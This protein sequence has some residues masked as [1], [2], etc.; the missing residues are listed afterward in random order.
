MDWLQK[1]KKIFVCYRRADRPA[2]A[3]CIAQHLMREFGSDNVFID[4][5]HV[6]LGENFETKVRKEVA[7]CR[8]MLVIIGPDW[9]AFDV[10]TGRPRV[11]EDDDLVR[12]EIGEA[13]RQKLTVIPIIVHG[14]RLPSKAELPPELA[15]LPLLNAQKITISRFFTDMPALATS[16]R[17]V[18]RLPLVPRSH[19][20]WRARAYA[21]AACA[22]STI[23]GGAVVHSGMVEAL[24][25]SPGTI[26]ALGEVAAAPP[27]AGSIILGSASGPV[28][29]PTPFAAHPASMPRV[30]PPAAPPPPAVPS[31]AAKQIPRDPQVMV[32]RFNDTNIPA[33]DRET[34]AR[35]LGDI[36]YIPLQRRDGHP[37]PWLSA[38]PEQLPPR[39]QFQDCENCPEMVA[40]PTGKF[41]MGSNG[42]ATNERDAFE[43][44]IEMPFAI[45][46]TETT[47]SQYL[48]YLREN[49]ISPSTWKCDRNLV[50]ME[51]GRQRPVEAQQHRNEPANCVSWQDA[52]DYVLW[53]SRRTGRFYRLPSEAEWEYAA[54]AGGAFGLDGA[55]LCAYANAQLPRSRGAHLPAG[56]GTPLCEKGGG[57]LEVASGQSNPFALHDMHGSVAE[58]VLDCYHESYTEK[59]SLLRRR[60]HEAWA[61]EPHCNKAT[62]RGTNSAVVV[63]GV[64]RGGHWRSGQD[65]VRSTAREPQNPNSR[66]TQIGFRVVRTLEKR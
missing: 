34:L 4:I 22:A 19:R 20:K 16:L 8:V 10:N 3:L 57:L 45:A 65:A 62:T 36:G 2:H 25:R 39:S 11:K 43:Q 49:N 28:A 17:E 26:R 35:Q 41:Q 44:T 15:E 60:G 42:G 56:G 51:L 37:V 64:V 31:P 18:G 40:L 33:S 66:T 48:H 46:R 13:L 58:W 12:A 14:A 7:K 52:I 1:P 59:P 47:V 9:L 53:L 27:A 6:K 61:T 24:W 21:A 29:V 23:V 5:G 54:R 50:R 38:P 32:A 63:L 55:E 30:A